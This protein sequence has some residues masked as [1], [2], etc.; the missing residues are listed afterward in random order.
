MRPV[1]IVVIILILIVAASMW[2]FN[3]L[4]M[5]SNSITQNLEGLD[6][7][8]RVGKW[9]EAQ[10]EMQVVEN[11]WNKIKEG[12]S[13]TV[14]HEEIDKI[15]LGIAKTREFVKTMNIENSLAEI[16]SLKIL[17]KHIPE[18]EVLNFKNIF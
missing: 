12:W 11:E 15:D 4:L 18:N 13:I 5:S 16:S 1:M 7:K 6:S 10:E 17:F 9:N 8:I 2:N 14:N 3:Y